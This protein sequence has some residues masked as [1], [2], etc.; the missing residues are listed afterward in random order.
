ML[1]GVLL[2]CLELWEECWTACMDALD[3]V[4]R[5]EDE[6]ILDAATM[7]DFMFDN[8][9][10]RSRLYFQTLQ[11]L[12]VFSDSILDTGR[13]IHQLDS[14]F[15]DPETARDMFCMPQNAP[16]GRSALSQEL[17]DLKKNWEFVTKF[18]SEA[19]VRLVQQ[20][21]A[22]IAEIQGLRDG[23]LNATSLRETAE[24]TKMNRYIIVFTVVTVLYLPPTFIATVFG[25][26]LFHET[27][28]TETINK[29]KI[30][31]VAASIG[32]YI[33]AFL[34]IL[35]VERIG[36]VQSLWAWVKGFNPQMHGKLK[37]W[38]LNRR[39]EPD[40]Q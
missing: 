8:A 3:D 13:D 16:F 32:T 1:Q 28:L 27:E 40:L 30:A 18:H 35:M 14:M 39:S 9:F 21:Q 24:S 36:V 11:L 15:L 4:V 38:I 37:R 2:H 20:V 34:L 10:Q 31:T 17:A 25:T 7:A 33:L 6:D 29:Y 23:P 26:D 22:K 12:R 5:V 19:E